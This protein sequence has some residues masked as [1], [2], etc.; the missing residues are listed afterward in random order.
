MGILWKS[1]KTFDTYRDIPLVIVERLLLVDAIKT[2]AAAVLTRERLAIAALCILAAALT[3]PFD[4]YKSLSLPMLVLYWGGV[5]LSSIFIATFVQEVMRP[6][7]H[8][9]GP[10]QQIVGYSLG[11]GLVYG[12][13]CYLWTWLIVPPLDGPLIGF[14]WFLAD[15]IVISFLIFAL[16][17]ILLDRLKLE[18]FRASDSGAMPLLEEEEEARPK[19]YRRIAPDDPGPILRIEAM[20]HFVDVVTPLAVYQLRLRFAD[21][22]EQMEGVEGIITHRSHWVARDAIAG[23]QRENGRFFLRLTNCA[24]VPVSRKY[25]PALEE[26]GLI[27]VFNVASEQPQPAAP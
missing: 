19:L 20:D 16:R 27:P 3:G 9:A 8:H 2:A 26:I 1:Q 21:A 14:H 24:L 13:L 6:V 5:I 25:R 17:L 15:V 10:W 23:F 18:A 4:T 7:L 22:I 12:P 11:M